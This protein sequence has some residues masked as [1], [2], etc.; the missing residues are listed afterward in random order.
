M[1]YK[2][3]ILA[4][5]ALAAIAGAAFLLRPAPMHIAA[6]PRVA[7]VPGMPPV[8][9]AQNLYSEIG[10]AHL[11]AAVRGDLERIY[12]PN[13]RSNDVSVIDPA[14]MKVVDRFKVGASPQHVIP[15]WEI[16]RASCRERVL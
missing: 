9:V 10:P 5:A 7:T 12:V 6:P 15:S 16:G 3:T 14:S 2:K 8:V 13:L 11:S 1:K 4:V